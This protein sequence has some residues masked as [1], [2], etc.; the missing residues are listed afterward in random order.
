VTSGAATLDLVS[1]DPLRD[2]TYQSTRLGRSVVDFLAW[3][4]LQR[5]RPRTLDQYERDLAR[6]CL[7]FP[8][9][10][11]DEITDSD[12]LHIA[13]SFKPDERRSRVQAW[14]SFYK[15]ARKTRKVTID[16]CD[17]LPELKQERRTKY[18]LFND[19]EKIALCSLPLRDGALMR[20]LFDSGIRNEEARHLTLDALRARGHRNELVVTGKGDKQRIIPAT[21]D[22]AAA[23]SELALLEGLESTDFLWYGCKKVPQAPTRILR[24]RPIAG[25]TFWG[26]W[27][28]SLDHANV[29]YRNPHI[30]RHTFATHYLRDGGTLSLLQDALGH[31]SI[32]TTDDYYNHQNTE[33]L[34]VE[35][36]RVFA[37]NR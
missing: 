23:V 37:I 3:K 13:A 31:A 19:L 15:W 30:T 10:A 20:I 18:D 11:I 25:S 32:S 24:H 29:P 2:K 34:H 1:F 16:P 28:R 6:G 21:P 36:E 17:V 27:N 12:M 35:F 8:D 22:L 9:K 14:R 4:E 33:D 5:R 26:W 7:M